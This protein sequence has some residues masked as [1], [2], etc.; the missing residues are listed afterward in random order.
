LYRPDATLSIHFRSLGVD[1]V[2]GHLYLGE[3]TYD[4]IVRT[5]LDGSN[6]VTIIQFPNNW[7]FVDVEVD[8]V[9]RGL[10]W[11]EDG[12]VNGIHRANLDGSGIEQIVP[13]VDTRHIGLDTAEGKIYWGT[14]VEGG[15]GLYRANL[16]GSSAEWV[17]ASNDDIYG[18]DIGIPEPTAFTIS[19]TGLAALALGR[20]RRAT[21]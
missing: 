16:D 1:L 8:S 2:A 18:L 12:S 20:R 17:L 9:R 15:P 10:Y 14:K 6:P 13:D 21:S 3:S 5:N 11:A 19:A 7:D 4:R